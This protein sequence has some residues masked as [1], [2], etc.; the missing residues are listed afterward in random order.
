LP[1]STS[2]RRSQPRPSDKAQATRKALVELAAQL[3]AENGYLET[4]IRDIARHA[5]MTSGAIYGNF[6]N[7][8]ELLAEAISLRTA[9]ELETAYRIPN[10]ESAHV[11]IL[12]R[13]SFRY[14]ERRQLRALILEGAAAARTDD[15]TRERLRDEQ[16]A[17]LDAWIAGYTEHRSELGIDPSVDIPDAVLYTWAAEVGLGIL[18]AMGIEPRSRRSWADMAAR[19]GRSLALP[20][21]KAAAPKKSRS[22][23]R[24]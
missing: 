17:H 8:A 15:E 12:R 4:S 9:S 14:A 24:A 13:L 16:L 1:N 5:S 11:E 2:S 22:A 23:K 3:F 19:F 10:G 18:E 21:E 6:R 20:P 7:K